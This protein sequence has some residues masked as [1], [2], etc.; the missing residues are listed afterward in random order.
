VR[1]RGS[2]KHF[3]SVFVVADVRVLLS[4]VKVECET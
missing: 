1:C 4:A 2:R 3:P